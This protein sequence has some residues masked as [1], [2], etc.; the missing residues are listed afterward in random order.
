[1]IIFVYIEQFFLLIKE[2]KMCQDFNE[3]LSYRIKTNLI[4]K[5]ILK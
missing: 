1:M 5:Y 2:N 4:K 3:K